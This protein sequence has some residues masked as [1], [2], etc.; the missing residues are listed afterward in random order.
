[1]QIQRYIK[2]ICK[3]VKYKLFQL[4]FD[5]YTII[6]DSE[7]KMESKINTNLREIYDL[8]DGLCTNISPHRHKDILKKVTANIA[9][10]QLC[11]ISN[12]QFDEQTV[13]TKVRNY[14]GSKSQKSLELFLNLHEELSTLTESHFRT[15]ILAF[16]LCLSEKKLSYAF[17]S[18]LSLDSVSKNSLQ[19]NINIEQTNRE[20]KVSGKLMLLKFDR[21]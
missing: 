21:S 9:D 20:K 16:M 6:F 14:L 8:L 12:L 18:K 4:L 11:F 7:I 3:C 5:I 1:V 17:D 10:S 13:L 2:S 19:T 15:S